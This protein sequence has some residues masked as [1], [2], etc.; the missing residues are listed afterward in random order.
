MMTLTHRIYYLMGGV[1]RR[2][3]VV[4]IPVIILPIIGGL[5][6][7]MGKQSYSTHTSMLIQETAKHNPFLEDFALSANL[8]DRM[9]GLDILLHS[10]HILRKVALSE[11][12]ITK[13]TPDSKVD[14][15][16]ADLSSKIVMNLAGADLINITYKSDE[17][18]GMK[19]VLESVSEHFIEELLAPE[20]SS[21]EKSEEFLSRQLDKF[22]YD[23]SE[24]EHKLA[25][26]KSLHSEELPELYHSAISRLSSL[27]HKRLEKKSELSGAKKSLEQLSAR[28]ASTSPVI[29]KIEEELV[30]LKSQLVILQARY[31]NEHSAIKGLERKI[32]RL[33][34]DRSSVMA[35][36]YNINTERLWDLA[37][38]V[39]PSNAEKSS[40]LLLS[41]LEGLQRQ[42]SQ[43]ESL[44][45]ELVGLDFSIEK[46]EKDTSNHGEKERRLIELQRDLNV[47]RKFYEE[48]LRRYEMARVTRELGRFEQDERIK[49]IDRPFKPSFS[50]NPAPILFVLSGLFGGFFLG[51]GLVVILEMIDS[52]IRRRDQLVKI[53]EVPVLT[54][55]PSIDNIHKYRI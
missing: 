44:E 6:G 31:T 36:K 48:L 19:E 53:T 7:V 55:L 17:A 45:G 27:R 5:V 3:Y 51:L 39:D 22:E 13:D 37:S 41:Q 23:L 2:R 40:P 30:Q 16:I 1:W 29:G 14:N 18:E 25:E 10:R 49:V 43:I 8:K 32:E 21:V 46:L 50:S 4:V 24:A 34:K 47:K 33:E 35:K 42:K 20:R 38:S 28:L 54:R 9:A 12:L 52:S 15:V 26:Y 11:S